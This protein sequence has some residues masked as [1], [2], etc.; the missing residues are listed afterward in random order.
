VEHQFAAFLETKAGRSDP[1]EWLHD[2]RSFELA[3]LKKADPAKYATWSR[4]CAAD[5]SNASQVN[6]ETPPPNAL[7]ER[8]NQKA[9]MT[10]GKRAGEAQSKRLW[11]FWGLKL[12]NS[13]RKLTAGLGAISGL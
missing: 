3:A 13:S 6:S 2:Q 1:Q 5:A 12:C 4:T 8:R 7:G 9:K 11:A 10:R